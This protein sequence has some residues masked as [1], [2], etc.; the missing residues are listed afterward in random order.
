MGREGEKR[1]E[2]RKK[3]NGHVM[4][5]S[6]RSEVSDDFYSLGTSAEG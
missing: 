6:S 2:R 4:R 5:V 3:G 1:R